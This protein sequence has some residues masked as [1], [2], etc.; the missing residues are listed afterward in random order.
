MSATLVRRHSRYVMLVK[1]GNKDTESVVSALI[2]QSQRL[3]S[4]LYRSLT[5]DRAKRARRSSAPDIGHRG[6]GLFL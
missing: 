6:R 2:K 4:E 1:V 5:W 3:P